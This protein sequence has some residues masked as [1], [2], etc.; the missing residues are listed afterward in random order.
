MEPPDDTSCNLLY[1]LCIASVK[2]WEAY[3]SLRIAKVNFKGL[4]TSCALNVYASAR[5]NLE[6]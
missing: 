3:N 1:S 6:R 4:T 2:Q 5:H